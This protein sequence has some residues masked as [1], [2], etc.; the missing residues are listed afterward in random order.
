RDFHVTG[1]QTCALPIYGS[2][3]SNLIDVVDLM[4]A[5]PKDY[6]EITRKSGGVQDWIWKGGSKTPTCIDLI[7]NNPQHL[8]GVP[9]RHLL[10]FR[11]EERRVGTEGRSGGT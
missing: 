3:K 6:S 11:S 10:E 1:V 2:G 9:L 5:S 8:R 4:R 7:I